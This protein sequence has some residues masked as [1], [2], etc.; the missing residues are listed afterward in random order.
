[1]CPV[2]LMDSHICAHT[3]KYN[4]NFFFKSSQYIMNNVTSD[5]KEDVI[6]KALTGRVAHAFNPSAWEAVAGESL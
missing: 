2:A 6:K 4:L 3:H 5:M 1:M